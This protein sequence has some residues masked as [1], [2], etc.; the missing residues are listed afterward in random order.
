MSERERLERS[1]SLLLVATLR[2]FN[3][4]NIREQGHIWFGHLPEHC[5]REG[6]F[7]WHEEDGEEEEVEE[8]GEVEEV[9]E[10]HDS[11]VLLINWTQMLHEYALIS[12]CNNDHNISVHII[13]TIALLLLPLNSFPANSQVSLN[14]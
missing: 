10:L 13:L 3:T 6:G 2:S 11:S 9:A 5:A 12:G 8:G 14:F 1:S 7:G 4:C